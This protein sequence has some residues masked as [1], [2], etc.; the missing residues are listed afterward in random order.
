LSHPPLHEAQISKKHSR[1]KMTSTSK[2]I[3][4]LSFNH[5]V[6]RTVLEAR[7]FR[8][9]SPLVSRFI[10]TTPVL[11]DGELAEKCDLNL[12]AS[13]YPPIPSGPFDPLPDVVMQNWKKH[14]S[15]KKEVRHDSDGYLSDEMAIFDGSTGMSRTFKQYY[16][17]TK[18]IAGTLKP[19]LGV[20]EKACVCL[21]APNHVDYLPVTL[22]VGLCGAK[23]A[24]VNPLYKKKEL[25]IVLEKSRTSVLIAHS[26]I[27]DVALEATKDSTHVKHVIV[28]TEDG[29]EAPE[30]LNSLKSIKRH[31]DGFDK[32]IRYIHTETDLHPYLLPY[33]SGTTGMPKGVCL[34]Q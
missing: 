28:M 12:V 27:L 7:N 32:T 9:L 25:Q 14:Y 4:K 33:S 8:Q 19:E 10:S 34:T 15:S 31:K 18:G 21:F 6:N 5:S 11:H 3:A 16:M 26:A 30:G 22:A 13:P 2:L 23:L 29:Q 20:D 24:P 17:D 1:H